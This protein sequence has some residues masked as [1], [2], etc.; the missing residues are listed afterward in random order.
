MQI[1][2]SLKIHIMY[3]HMKKKYWRYVFFYGNFLCTVVTFHI[4]YYSKL[5]LFVHRSPTAKILEE[6]ILF[7]RPCW[8]IFCYLKWTDLVFMC[9]ITLSHQKHLKLSIT[10]LVI[11]FLIENNGGCL[12][13]SA[14]DTAICEH[15]K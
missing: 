5:F 6:I 10:T 9:R 3:A 2:N 7:H 13:C 15:I 11:T 8:K 1:E 4:I 14:K 12:I